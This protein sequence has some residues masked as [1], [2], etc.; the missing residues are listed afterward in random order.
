[1]IDLPFFLYLMS[2]PTMKIVEHLDRCICKCGYIRHWTF[3]MKS[4]TWNPMIN[5]MDAEL[6]D[7]K[8]VEELYNFVI[9]RKS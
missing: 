1:M 7:V 6:K 4:G 8:T 5:E 3:A 9:S 2:A